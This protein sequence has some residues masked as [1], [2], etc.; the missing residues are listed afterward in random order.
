MIL[1]KF[2]PSSFHFITFPLSKNDYQTLIA[3]LVING[4]LS[5]IPINRDGNEP[6]REKG[7]MYLSTVFLLRTLDFNFIKNK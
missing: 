4:R 1:F 6:R 2:L 3:Y 5:T 7:V